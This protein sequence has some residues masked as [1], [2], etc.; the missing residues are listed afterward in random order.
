MTFIHPIPVGP[1]EEE[2]WR[3]LER[4]LGGSDPMTGEMKMWALTTAPS[5]WQICDGSVAGSSALR[6]ALDAAGRPHGGTAGAGL[7]PDMR[8]RTPVGPGSSGA[9]GATTHTLGQRAGEETHAL[10]VGEM[11]VHA[12]GPGAGSNFVIDGAGGSDFVAG[13]NWNVTTSTANAGGGGAHTNM[14]PYVGI[15]FIIKL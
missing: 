8:G 14:Q 7:V 12:H 3:E 15:N 11:P 4:H 5:G 2:N 10:T 6:A 13:G 9:V 1:A